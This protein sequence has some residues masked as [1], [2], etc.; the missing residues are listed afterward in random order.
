MA[1]VPRGYLDSA[2][3]DGRPVTCKLL[4]IKT[5]GVMITLAP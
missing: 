4:P 2:V 5:G 3:S 1:L